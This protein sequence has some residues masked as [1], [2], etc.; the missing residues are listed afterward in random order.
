MSDEQNQQASEDSK[1]PEDSF[2]DDV[3]Y[4]AKETLAPNAD[5]KNDPVP[6]EEK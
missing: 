6:G 2:L 4:V 1:M 5:P 3:L